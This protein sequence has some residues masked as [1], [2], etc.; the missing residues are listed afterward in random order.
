MKTLSF[1]LLLLVLS[2]TSSYSQKLLRALEKA[3]TSVQNVTTSNTN[4]AVQS[5]NNST[6][7]NEVPKSEFHTKHTGK[8]L[9][10]Q[11][12]RNVA[13][14]DESQLL[15][16]I[17]LKQPCYVN[18][19]LEAPLF[20]TKAQHEKIGQYDIV[21]PHVIRN[22]YI[23]DQLIAS[24]ID[25][26]TQDQFRNQPVLSDIIVPSNEY[27]L[28]D[29]K[30]RLGLLAHVFSALDAGAHRLRI[31]YQINIS[32]PKSAGNGSAATDYENKPITVAS[33]EVMLQISPQTLTDYCKR[34]GRPKFSKGVLAGQPQ[35]EQ[36]LT[37]FIKT[38]KGHHPIYVYADDNWTLRRG[39]FNR[40]VSRDVQVYYIFTNATGRCEMANFVATQSFDG[41]TYYPPKEGIN[42]MGPGFKFATCQQYQ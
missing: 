32:Q 10:A 39:D 27:E 30:F 33:G 9:F 7:S 16:T 28:A 37:S 38:N 14:A 23:N 11:R 21:S 5:S 1:I 8:I 19:Y 25:P 40:V 24:Y 4:D 17:D 42:K 15:S 36:Q 22:Y 41:S 13:L 6:S 3:K 26:I 31:D 35:L 18:A 20:T 2:N 12:A 34:Y 29:N